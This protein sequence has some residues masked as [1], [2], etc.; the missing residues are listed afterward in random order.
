MFD[1]FAQLSDPSQVTTAQAI[2]GGS[3][4]LSGILSGVLSWLLLVYIPRKDKQLEDMIDRN[5]T[6]WDKREEIYRSQVSELI[7]D[8]KVAVE[9]VVEHC[10]RE[11]ARIANGGILPDR[12]KTIRP[13]V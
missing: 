5:N 7:K 1:L 8:H 12:A 3:L 4:T 10:E 6:R 9:L 11:F 2:S 13:T